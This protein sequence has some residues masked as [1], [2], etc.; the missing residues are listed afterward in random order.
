[1]ASLVVF[2]VQRYGSLTRCWRNLLIWLGLLGLLC[3]PLSSALHDFSVRQQMDAVFGRFKSGQRKQLDVVKK[4]PVLWS[5]VRM[6]YSNVRVQDNIAVL[7]LVL[8]AP[9]DLLTQSVL[10]DVYRRM[11]EKAVTLGLEDIDV[12]ISVIPNRVYRFDPDG[13]LPKGKT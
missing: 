12:R 5:K 13:P 3:I 9:E 1:M 8:N 10:D 2:L 7:D 11:A 6:M 4:D